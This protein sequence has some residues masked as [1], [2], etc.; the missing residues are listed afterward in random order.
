MQYKCLNGRK[1]CNVQSKTDHPCAEDEFRCITSGACTPLGDK[2]NKYFNCHDGSDEKNCDGNI[3]SINEYKSMTTCTLNFDLF[4]IYSLFLFTPFLAIY[5][6]A[7]RTDVLP[8]EFA[9]NTDFFP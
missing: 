7:T 2:C 3:H 1:K 4:T 5:R 6:P 9:K 8:L